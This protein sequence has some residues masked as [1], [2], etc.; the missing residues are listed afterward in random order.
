MAS[1]ARGRA[2]P[3]PPARQGAPASPSPSACF[4]SVPTHMLPTPTPEP[5]PRSRRAAWA[6]PLPR[7]RRRSTRTRRTGT[8]PRARPPARR[9]PPRGPGAARS[10]PPAPAPACRRSGQ[11]RPRCTCFGVR[12]EQKVLAQFVSWICYFH[13]LLDMVQTDRRSLRW[14]SVAV[15]AVKCAR[16][17][18][19]SSTW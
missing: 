9:A 19:V 12:L 16:G 18:R 6:T 10:R 14:Q 3:A 8:E 13:S 1:A 15:E 4:S 2:W 7:S 17:K 5:A 11:R